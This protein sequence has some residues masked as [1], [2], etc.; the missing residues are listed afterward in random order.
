VRT[1]ISVGMKPARSITE[2]IYRQLKLELLQCRLKPG[3][4][5]RT[6]E[7]SARFG[8]SLSGIREALSRLSADGLVET[9]P[10]RG[11]RAAPL[12]RQDLLALTEAAIAIDSICIRQSLKQ[13]NKSWE[14]RLIKA[15]DK[16]LSSVVMSDAGGR[17]N[18][19]FMADHHDFHQ[20]LIAACDNRW[21]L[22]MRDTC[23]LQ[24]ERYRQLCV[25]RSPSLDQIN[26]GYREITEA[27]I[28]RDG[29]RASE[30]MAVQFERNAQRFLDALEDLDSLA[31][32]SDHD[33][34][35]ADET[36]NA[37]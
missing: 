18:M 17:L 24:A 34:R 1:S 7:L 14:Q 30:L 37:F 35:G 2:Q 22:K 6:N 11:F 10:Q 32:W 27:A 26:A 29:D 21:L 3:E 33:E 16:V 15:R 19:Q 8:V 4:R 5:L 20:A 31:F 25:P 9:D 28:A 12:S 23:N 36:I 13:G